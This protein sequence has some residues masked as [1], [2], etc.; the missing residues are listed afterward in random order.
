MVDKIKIALDALD[1][2][3]P[4]YAEEFGNTDYAWSMMYWHE[5]AKAEDTQAFD[6]AYMYRFGY[7]ALLLE[8]FDDI[9]DLEAEDIDRYEKRYNQLKLELQ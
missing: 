1:L 7:G 3:K 9:S 5:R 6:D 8:L 4:A 2:A